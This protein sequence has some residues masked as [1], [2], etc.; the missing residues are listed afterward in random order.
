MDPDLFGTCFISQIMLTVKSL[1]F[2][3]IDFRAAMIA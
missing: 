3:V 2:K 1:S